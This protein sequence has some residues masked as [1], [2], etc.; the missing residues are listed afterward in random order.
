M[1]CVSTTLLL[2]HDNALSHKA[3]IAK[4]NV[5]I[6]SVQMFTVTILQN[7]VSSVLLPFLLIC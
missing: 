1:L 6:T 5:V 2:L 4:V 3:L 7:K